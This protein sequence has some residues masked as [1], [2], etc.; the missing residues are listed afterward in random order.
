MHDLPA[1][2]LFL[3][4]EEAQHAGTTKKNGTTSKCNNSQR[5]PNCS[6]NP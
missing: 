3:L 6:D 2:S 1:T 5:T 4:L